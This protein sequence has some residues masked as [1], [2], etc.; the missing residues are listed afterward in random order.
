M[1]GMVIGLIPLLLYLS[2]SLSVSGAERREDE[3]DE[4]KR[5]MKQNFQ[6]NAGMTFGCQV[7]NCI[8]RPVAYA[9]L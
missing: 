4:E 9:K 3:N 1:T 2:L 8:T 6:E 7:V 5:I